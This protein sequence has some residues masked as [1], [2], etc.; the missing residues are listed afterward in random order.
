MLGIIPIFE[1]TWTGGILCLIF[2]ERKLVPKLIF[3]SIIAIAL[4]GF[5]IGTINYVTNI[6]WS[7]LY[8]KFEDNFRLF[9]L[10]LYVVATLFLLALIA[11]HVL[12]RKLVFQVIL[13][14]VVVIYGLVRA[15]LFIQSGMAEYSALPEGIADFLRDTFS[16]LDSLNEWIWQN[17]KAR[18]SIGFIF[19]AFLPLVAFISLAGTMAFGKST[20]PE[21]EVTNGTGEKQ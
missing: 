2:A 11:V 19:G 10:L 18:P 9:K 12:K 20:R 15:Y 16:F 21:G 1:I 4:M 17:G 14:L 6:Y 7:E 8:E 5:G 3:G 13:G